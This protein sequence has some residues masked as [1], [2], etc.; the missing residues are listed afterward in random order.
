MSEKGV[1]D[2]NQAIHRRGYTKRCE[3]RLGIYS[4]H[5]S[6]VFEFCH[7]LHVAPVPLAIF[8]N[9]C[10]L[11]TGTFMSLRLLPWEVLTEIAMLLPG[12]DLACLR[13]VCVSWCR[14][15]QPWLYYLIV[16]KVVKQPDVGDKSIVTTGKISNYSRAEMLELVRIDTRTRARALKGRCSMDKT[17]VELLW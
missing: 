10:F 2:P 13:A 14:T 4:V 7:W 8:F 1:K 17:A 12:G 9:G 11:S 5:M 3:E 15:L 16:A 6:I